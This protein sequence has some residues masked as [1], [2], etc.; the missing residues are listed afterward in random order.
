MLERASMATGNLNCP[1][2][3]MEITRKA[4]GEEVSCSRV[5]GAVGNTRLQEG[6]CKGDDV[7]QGFMSRR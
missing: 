1:R 7:A 4:S 6:F 3:P 2:V 5:S